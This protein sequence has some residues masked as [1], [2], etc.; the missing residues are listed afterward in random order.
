ME[1]LKKLKDVK[2]IVMME[3]INERRQN[4]QSFAVNL[5]HE[6]SFAA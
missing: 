6:E 1:V 4:P 5:L 2:A 3:L